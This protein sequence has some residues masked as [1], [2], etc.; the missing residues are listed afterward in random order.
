[1]MGDGYEEPLSR[2]AKR[3]IYRP[4]WHTSYIDFSEK[5]TI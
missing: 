2:F 3:V 5:G 4:S 1:M